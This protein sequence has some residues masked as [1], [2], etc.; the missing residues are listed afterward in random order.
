MLRRTRWRHTQADANLGQGLYTVLDSDNWLIGYVTSQSRARATSCL[1]IFSASLHP[2]VTEL[3]TSNMKPFAI[4]EYYLTQYLKF[5]WENKAKEDYKPEKNGPGLTRSTSACVRFCITF[6]K[7]TLFLCFSTRE[8]RMVVAKKTFAT[9][10]APRLCPRDARVNSIG[11]EL[12]DYQYRLTNKS[13]R[14]E[15]S[16]SIF[17]A[18]TFLSKRSKK[19]ENSMSSPLT[20]PRFWQI[21]LLN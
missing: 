21:F 13:R 3:E 15:S 12:H 14:S 4:S 18:S 10:S 19:N 9:A 8:K 2:S 11:C 7:C 17:L 1:S 6:R 20:F 16:D 5:R